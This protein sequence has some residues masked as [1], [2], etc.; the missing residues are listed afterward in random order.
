MGQW[1]CKSETMSE[2]GDEISRERERELGQRNLRNVK[3]NPLFD[4]V[5]FHLS[6]ESLPNHHFWN[7]PTGRRGEISAKGIIP[8]KYIDDHCRLAMTER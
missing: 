5:P 1:T 6:L 4:S 2:L 3:Y 7:D 8:A